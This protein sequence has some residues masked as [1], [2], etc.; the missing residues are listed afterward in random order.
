M[1]KEIL[2]ADERRPR[3]LLRNSIIS[4]I[5]L[6]LFLWS[7]DVMVMASSSQS[8]IET[9]FN[10]LRAFIEPSWNLLDNYAVDS[11]WYLMVE[12]IGIGILGTL[13]GAILSLPIAIL[14][15]RNIVGNVISVIGNSL[16]SVI[17]TFP[18]FILGLMFVRVTGPGPFTGVLTIATLSIGMIAKMFAEAIETIDTGIL[19]A[20]D[21]AGA[22]TYQKI[23]YG[24]IPQLLSNFVS[25][26]LHRFEINIK[27]ATVLGL[28]GAGGIGF[29]LLSAMGAFRWQDA[30]ASL[31]GI[32]VC[33]LVIELFSNLVRERLVKGE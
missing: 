14:S 2:L 8:G 24:V 11:T 13:I 23:R 26:V 10:I 12:T 9:A 3:T 21:A 19:Q 18:L 5:L 1:E 28:V 27:N 22:T 6:G 32:I 25:I 16:I 33:V 29:S 20:M 7:W 15:S 17:R 31:W 30:A 4:L